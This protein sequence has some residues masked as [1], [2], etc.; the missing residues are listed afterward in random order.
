MESYRATVDF[1]AKIREAQA[2]G[3]GWAE[4]FHEILQDINEQI[5]SQGRAAMEAVRRAEVAQNSV[6]RGSKKGK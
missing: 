4:P 1:A 2:R 5:E 3:K 6:E